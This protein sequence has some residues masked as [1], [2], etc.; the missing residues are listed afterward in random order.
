MVAAYFVA[1]YFAGANHRGQALSKVEWEYKIVHLQQQGV[2]EP[3]KTLNQLGS[4]GWE[5]VQMIRTDELSEKRGI[6]LL[7]RAK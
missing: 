7:K 6:Y 1:A 3:E 5:L 2:G 4:D